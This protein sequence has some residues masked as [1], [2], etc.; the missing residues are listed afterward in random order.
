M[1]A[2]FVSSNLVHA[3]LFFWFHPMTMTKMQL[4]KTNLTTKGHKTTREPQQVLTFPGED[5][6]TD[7]L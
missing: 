2:P 1:I 7:I 6:V 5:V 3:A 4:A